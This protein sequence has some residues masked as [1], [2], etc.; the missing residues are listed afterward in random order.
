[1]RYLLELGADRP[2]HRREHTLDTGG[3]IM[4]LTD[5]EIERLKRHVEAGA[6]CRNEI[7]TPQWPDAMEKDAFI[8]LA[9][10]IVDT[11]APHSEA[12]KNGLL[13]QLLVTIGNCIGA[14]PY[15]RVESTH[16][17][18]NLYAV[19]VGDTAK[20]RKGTGSDRIKKI[21][22]MADQ[23]WH[24]CLANG[25]SSGEGLIYQVRD[26]EETSDKRL[27]VIEGEFAQA[28]K[29]SRRE[30]NTLSPVMRNAWDGGILRTLT[31]N[32]PLIA[33]DAHVSIIGHI[34]QDEL[35]RHLCQ[36]D[37]ANGFAN[38]FLWCCVRRSQ[39][40]P[41]GGDLDD[42]D[43]VP[44][45]SRLRDVFSYARKGGAVR[46]GDDARGLWEA[47]YS[48]LAKSTEA[49]LIGAMT[50]R[51]EAQMVRLAML[52][53]LLDQTSVI[54]YDHLAA[55]KAVVN[56]C[57]R[58]VKYLFWSATGNH[59]ADKILAALQDTPQISRMAVYN[60]GARHWRKQDVDD[61]IGLLVEGYGVMEFNEPTGGRAKRYLIRNTNQCAG[62]EP[63]RGF[64]C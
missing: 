49:G 15:Y 31:R 48:S 35:I 45:A 16:H 39:L 29:V 51:D 58:S 41:Y 34:T 21:I 60:M 38:R 55:A 32:S 37:M 25:M 28:L 61:A 27:M 20:A 56:Y 40:L 1:L 44:L 8:G 9:G 57:Y 10:E 52:Y 3:S 17:H 42:G 33:S 63:K 6:E 54:S 62:F 43:L 5:D 59:I 47:I 18:T 7:A 14:S 4:N 26:S 50:A 24:N 64:V 11:V 46:M 19:I 13:L 22:L 2:E 36:T 12:D 30:G 53:A 23:G